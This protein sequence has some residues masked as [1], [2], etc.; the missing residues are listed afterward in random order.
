MN[1]TPEW[2]VIVQ[3]LHPRRKDGPPDIICAV[4]SPIPDVDGYRLIW[5]HSS[6]K[7][8]GML[9]TVKIE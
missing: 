2:E 8:K 5:Y 3:Y 7:R 1:H 6:H 9:R 4:E